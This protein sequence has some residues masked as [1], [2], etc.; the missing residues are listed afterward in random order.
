MSAIR[1]PEEWK[2]RFV[3][4]LDVLLFIRE[5]ILGGVMPEMFFG[6]LDVGAL[7]AFVHGVRFHLYGGGVEDARYQEFSAWLRD[8]R[9]EFPAGKGWAGLY[10]EEAG[11]DHQAAIL[12]FLE[13]CAEYDSLTRERAT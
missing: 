12:R 13:R 3:P 5:Q 7:A 8:V 10:L 4:T 6:R 11:G 9:N 2:G 1:P